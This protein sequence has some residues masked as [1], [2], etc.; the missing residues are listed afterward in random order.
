MKSVGMTSREWESGLEVRA[1]TVVR[2]FRQTFGVYVQEV[3]EA[4]W[5]LSIKQDLGLSGSS[6]I[7]CKQNSLRMKVNSSHIQILSLCRQTSIYLYEE[8]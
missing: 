2:S 6:H 7:L 4:T 1:G 3:E 8:R 5:Q